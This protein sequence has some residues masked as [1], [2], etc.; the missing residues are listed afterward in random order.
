VTLTT[1]PTLA[2]SL[3]VGA[4]ILWRLYSRFRRL[5]GRQKLSTLRLYLTVGALPLLMAYLVLK[6]FARSGT[7]LFLI[8][9]I[10]LGAAI[11]WYGLRL[12]RF[13][14]T[15]EGLF[16]TPNAYIGIALTLLFVGRIGFRLL[17]VYFVS[18]SG[19]RDT[20]SFIRS[21]LTQLLLGTLATYYFVYALGLLRWRQRERLKIR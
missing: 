7:P 8:V 5:V 11:A 18:T 14:S 19:P 16:Y 4:L 15:S 1:H 17:Q 21:P 2:V 12:T 13:E 10:T 20:L 6:V 3:G 9:G